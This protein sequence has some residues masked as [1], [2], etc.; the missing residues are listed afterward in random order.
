MKRT[1]ITI[2]AICCIA[3]FAALCSCNGNPLAGLFS[4]NNSE[5][6]A[7]D[8]DDAQIIGLVNEWNRSLNN[9]DEVASESLYAPEV[10]FYTEN[11]SAAECSRARVELAMKDPSWKQTI[12]SEIYVEHSADGKII[13]SFTKQSDG[14]KGVNTY[15]S[16]LIFQRFGDD[17]KI[18]HESDKLTDYNIEHRKTKNRAVQV[19]EN[20]IRGDFDADG[21]IEHVWIE[22]KYDDEGYAIS[23][24]KLKSDN[25]KL[26]GINFGRVGRGVVLINVGD[27]N[28]SG[29]D[30]LGAIPYSESTWC[31]YF[32][33]GFKNGKWIQP[34]KS[35]TV[36]LGNDDTNRVWKSDRKGYINISCNEGETPDDAFESSYRQVKFNF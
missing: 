8:S 4:G 2:I 35:F 21:Q 31:E 6:K 9:R 1:L 13:A 10:F 16:Y 33:Y 28:N 15:P 26:D 17:W 3:A 27:L 32:L 11:R 30:F 14:K 25:P 18:V 29:R 36:W 12:V 34:I 23:D 7:D 5:Q 24:M 19:P 20:A 22:G